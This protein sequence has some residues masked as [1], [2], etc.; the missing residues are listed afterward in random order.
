MMF[1][2]KMCLDNHK[3]YMQ[4]S[5]LFVT[6]L[7]V[8]ASST[9]IPRLGPIDSHPSKIYKVQ[10][11]DPPLKRWE[12]ILRDFNSSVHRFVEFLE[13]LPIPKGFYDGVEWYAKNQ[14]KYQDFVA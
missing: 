1:R 6:F 9:V 7:L 5:L 2:C 13:L 10:I 3:S 14:F 12:P 11:D 4:T 8:L